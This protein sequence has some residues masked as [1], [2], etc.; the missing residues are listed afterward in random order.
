MPVPIF[1]ILVVLSPLID[2]EIARNVLRLFAVNVACHA[3]KWR[4]FT[5][6]GV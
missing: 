6:S 3:E 4:I 2:A 5:A 1:K